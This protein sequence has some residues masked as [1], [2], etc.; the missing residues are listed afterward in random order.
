MISSEKRKKFK[1]L[2]FD[3]TATQFKILQA[4]K[5][6]RK[7]QK[8]PAK[9]RCET[10][11]KTCHNQAA[12]RN[13]VEDVHRGRHFLCHV[14][15]IMIRGVYMSKLHKKQHP[16]NTCHFSIF[17]EAQK[18][19]ISWSIRSNF[20]DVCKEEFPDRH[21]KRH[22]VDD[23]HRGRYFTCNICQ[24]TINSYLFLPKHEKKHMTKISFKVSF[25]TK[26]SSSLTAKKR[27]KK[28]TDNIS[29]K[30]CHYC[31]KVF[32]RSEDAQYHTDTVH[33]NLR[34]LC[35]N[36]GVTGK[37]IWLH[38]RHK[39]CRHSSFTTIRDD[40]NNCI[41][42]SNKQGECPICHRVYPNLSV[43]V[44]EDHRSRMFQC[45]LCQE[46]FSSYKDLPKHKAS[47]SKEPIFT[48]TFSE[49]AEQFQYLTEDSKSKKC[50]ICPKEFQN[51]QSQVYHV[52]SYHKGQRFYCH[53]C[54]VIGKDIAF[55]RRE[56][57]S[58]DRESLIIFY[59][60]NNE[61]SSLPPKETLCKVC[62][63]EFPDLNHHI[64]EAH[65]SRKFH[66]NLCDE[67]IS[68]YKD[69]VGHKALHIEATTYKVSFSSAAIDKSTDLE[70]E[71]LATVSDEKHF[72]TL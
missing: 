59:D 33:E 34:Y 6:K 54:G 68:S 11:L 38:R 56:N 44:E 43:H 26:V 71:I 28:L 7:L 31:Q 18:D 29:P 32:K 20:C 1:S 57:E 15:G 37:A 65:R 55:H 2:R 36:C 46:R 62:T 23:V 19:K 49:L 5:I 30:K 67:E 27:I 69:L 41:T 16:P 22:H 25:S 12:K 52:N 13:H 21:K 70:K 47:H 9:N 63:R 8:N 45:D 48:V 4:Q 72:E 35:D 10:C 40:G 53:S 39:S 50:P 64:D 66:C 42:L 17:Y 51:R 61:C 24:E 60:T 58:C 14:C 3:K